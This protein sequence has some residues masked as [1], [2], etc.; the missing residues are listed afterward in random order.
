MEFR[1]TNPGPIG[2]I[3]LALLLTRRY[4]ANTQGAE[5]AR[6]GGEALYRMVQGE[7]LCALQIPL[8]ITIFIRLA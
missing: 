1:R 2:R 5:T 8:G 6:R 7:A 3:C 4:L